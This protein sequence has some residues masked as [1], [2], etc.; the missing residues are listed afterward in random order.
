[1]IIMKVWKI[2]YALGI[3]TLLTEI[4]IASLGFF[5]KVWTL[6]TIGIGCMLPSLALAAFSLMYGVTF[7]KP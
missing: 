7:D 6:S 5:L 3:G 2:L 1:M 4:M